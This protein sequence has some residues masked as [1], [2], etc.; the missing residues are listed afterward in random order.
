MDVLF[1]LT[2]GKIVKIKNVICTR[3]HDGIITVTVFDD[4]QVFFN[5]DHVIFYGKPDNIPLGDYYV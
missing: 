1:Y 4:N 3:I 2:N 5:L